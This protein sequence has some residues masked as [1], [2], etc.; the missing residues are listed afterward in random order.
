MQVRQSLHGI[1]AFVTV[2]ET[3]SFTTAAVRLNAT[4]PGISQRVRALEAQL[5]VKL[6]NREHA[7]VSPTPAG[8]VYYRHCIDILRATQAAEQA[9]RPFADSPDGRLRI[10]VSPAFT[11]GVLANTLARFMERFANVRITVQDV[12]GHGAIERVQD[13]DLDFVILPAADFPL[14]LRATLLAKVPEVLVSGRCSGRRQLEPVVLADQPALKLVLPPQGVTS[15]AIFERYFLDHGV[16][17]E[18][19]LAPDAP[20][21]ALSL[22][23]ESDWS[24]LQAATLFHS[25][26]VEGGRLIVNPVTEPAIIVDW[27]VVQPVRDRLSE[28]A[29]SFLTLLQADLM[30]EVGWWSGMV[31]R[32]LS[33][34]TADW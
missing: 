2:Y 7:Q 9:M 4:Q 8:E 24:S 31:G 6:F 1:L 13:G 29:R 10:G 22:V 34:A 20:G 32:D 17:V 3:G 23:A 30:D 21:V 18:Q 5:A 26:S 11:Q 12:H 14:S 27:V 15:R 33:V 28:P 19:V 16:K 25:G